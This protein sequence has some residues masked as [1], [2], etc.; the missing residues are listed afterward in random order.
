MAIEDE[1]CFGV[2]G[3][4]L[5]F[6]NHQSALGQ[7]GSET[8][9]TVE[10]VGGGLSWQ[11]GSQEF[12]PRNNSNNNTAFNNSSSNGPALTPLSFAAI[13]SS[14][15]SPPATPETL[16]TTA[17]TP[18]ALF[19]HYDDDHPAKIFTTIVAICDTP[20][21]SDV[22]P[23]LI[24]T[25]LAF[26]NGKLSNNTSCGGE[27]DKNSEEIIVNLNMLESDVSVLLSPA[28]SLAESL[29]LPMDEEDDE[30]DELCFS[31]DWIGLEKEKMRSQDNNSVSS[32]NSVIVATQID[33]CSNCED[34]NAMQED[35]GYTSKITTNTSTVA[36]DTSNSSG[37]KEG[38]ESS[39]NDD[40]D[41][42]DSGLNR[43]SS[44]SSAQNTVISN[45]DDACNH[46][47][48]GSCNGPEDSDDDSLRDSPSPPGVEVNYFPSVEE[49]ETRTGISFERTLNPG[50]GSSDCG[51]SSSLGSSSGNNFINHAHHYNNVNSDSNAVYTNL[52]VINSSNNSHN[53]ATTDPGHQR[54]V[55]I[56][57][58]EEDMRTIDDCE[59]RL[60]RF[61][62]LK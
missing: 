2:S 18:D 4:G 33:N 51:S 61:V 7:W 59:R 60:C 43:W 58:M 36:P 32:K 39:C 29:D 23:V 12:T 57:M 35:T 42:I 16:S 54:N 37:N 8:G 52:Q 41:P 3:D 1:C 5:D 27:N 28:S 22:S 38:G 56:K 11:E 10:G 13:S 50:S 6:W 48:P 30:Y 15:T 47:I 34:N 9:V 25:A 55:A 17:T 20:D 53:V 26:D 46:N 31:D 62:L 40:C 44:N 49:V 24:N 21:H 19:C 14:Q 45:E